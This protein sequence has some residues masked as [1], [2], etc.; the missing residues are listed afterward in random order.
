MEQAGFEIINE[1]LYAGMEELLAAE[2]PLNH[3]WS[4][5]EHIRS[6]GAAPN[7]KIPIARPADEQ[8]KELTR[9][10]LKDGKGW[11]RAADLIERCE[12]NEL[13]S[14]IVGFL[15]KIYARFPCPTTPTT[16]EMAD[17]DSR[18]ERCRFG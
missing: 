13:P 4:Y 11:G 3:Q 6:T 1:I 15:E 16:S 17:F 7:S 10:I 14:S 9:Q 18:A 2:V 12:I 8:I 5:L